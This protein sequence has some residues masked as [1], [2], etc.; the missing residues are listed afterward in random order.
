MWGREGG[1]HP[2]P[3]RTA[4]VLELHGVPLQLLHLTRMPLRRGQG[5]ASGGGTYKNIRSEGVGL[6]PSQTPHTWGTSNTQYSNIRRHSEWQRIAS[7]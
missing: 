6:G 5:L 7:K 1:T 3:L 4:L 2:G